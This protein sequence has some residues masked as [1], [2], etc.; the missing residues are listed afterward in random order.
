MGRDVHAAVNTQQDGQTTNRI[1]HSQVS[2]HLF[3]AQDTVLT[4]YMIV[5]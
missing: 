1:L 5:H 2:S 4:A 3:P